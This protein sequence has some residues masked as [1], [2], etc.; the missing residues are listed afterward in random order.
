MPAGSSYIAS[1]PRYAGKPGAGADEKSVVAVLFNKQSLKHASS[2]MQGDFDYCLKVIANDLTGFEHVS[3]KL[4]QDLDFASKAVAINGLCL[5]YLKKFSDD[6]DVVVVAVSQNGQ[7]LQY[8]S[9]PLTSDNRL[10]AEAMKNDGMAFVY[11]SERLRDDKETALEACAQNGL[12]LQYASAP[13]RKDLDVI[14]TALSNDSFHVEHVDEKL[15]QSNHFLH[16]MAS[17]LLYTGLVHGDEKEVERAM[18]AGA[19]YNYLHGTGAKFAAERGHTMCLRKICSITP[20]DS[21]MATRLAIVAKQHGRDEVSLFLSQQSEWMLKQGTVVSGPKPVKLEEVLLADEGYRWRWD[22][23]FPKPRPE[24]VEEKVKRDNF[25][26]AMMAKTTNLGEDELHGKPARKRASSLSRLSSSLFTRQQ[27]AEACQ[28]AAKGSRMRLGLIAL[29]SPKK[30]DV[31]DDKGWTPAHWAAHKNRPNIIRSL[32]ATGVERVSAPC[33][34]DGRTP[35]HIAAKRGFVKV[36]EALLEVEA[37]CDTQEDRGWS[38]LMLAVARTDLKSTNLL[39][40]AKAEL[41]ARNRDGQTVL[42]LAAALGKSPVLSALCAHAQA[43]GQRLDIVDQ[44]GRSLVDLVNLLPEFSL[45]R[46]AALEVLLKHGVKGAKKESLERPFVAQQRRIK[47][48]L[49][50]VNTDL[51]DSHKGFATKMRD[52]YVEGKDPAFHRLSAMKLLENRERRFNPPAAR[53]EAPKL[54]KSKSE[55]SRSE[56]KVSN[57]HGK[58]KT[59]TEM[60][61]HG[62]N[63]G[64]TRMAR[65]REDQDFMNLALALDKDDIGEELGQGE[66]DE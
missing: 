42:H 4:K 34:T 51:P 15:R 65:L 60:V 2:N 64:L 48:I 10:V 12:A 35:A 3:D 1:P 20:M 18:E 56:S 14:L 32:A 6:Y 9:R 22:K 38:P 57:I 31:V 8:A 55:G 36:L 43:S 24:T 16:L 23:L 25:Y 28:A 63:I 33:E 5:Q 17:H 30:L 13:L 62:N 59:I 37:D 46:A 54:K 41:N 39:I 27:T 50:P 7:A 66:G 53:A 49:Q 21:G 19:S 29:M 44:D 52:W 40:A 26:M 47:A 11:A 45:Q 58:E 61:L